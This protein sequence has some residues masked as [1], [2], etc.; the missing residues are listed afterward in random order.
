MSILAGRKNSSGRDIFPLQPE[1]V[2]LGGQ[3][4]GSQVAHQWFSNSS[5]HDLKD[6]LEHTLPDATVRA[7]DS[8]RLG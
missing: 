2:R 4:R 1:Q 3:E 6:L 8:V 7:S 5:L